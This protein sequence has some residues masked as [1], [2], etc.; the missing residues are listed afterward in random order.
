[1]EESP[2]KL[3][4]KPRSSDR[5]DPVWAQELDAPLGA[6]CSAHPEVNAP[7]LCDRCGDHLCFECSRESP[8]GY[9]TFCASCLTRLESEGGGGVI[10]WENPSL[11]FF[12]RFVRTVRGVLGNPGKFFRA[13]RTRDLLPAISFQWLVLGLFMLL[14]WVGIAAVLTMRGAF[15]PAL[16]GRAALWMGAAVGLAPALLFATTGLLH[17]NLWL[18][19]SRR[20]YLLTY[21]YNA[22]LSALVLPYGVVSLVAIV[23]IPPLRFILFFGFLGYMLYVT[24]V[25]A[26][27]SHRISTGRAAIAVVLH[28]V[29]MYFI[30]RYALGPLRGEV[31]GLFAS[32]LL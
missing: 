2:L 21:R 20:P 12:R 28:G 19:G 7:L 16:F 10:P 3:V 13:L 29:E 30:Y 14:L 17:A 5:V 31:L 1:M 32:E 25:A 26:K 24:V 6:K 27:A 22:Y 9:Q 11:G 18:V 4:A 23:P 8:W 15:L